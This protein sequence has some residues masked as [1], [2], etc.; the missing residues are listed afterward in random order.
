MNY[1]KKEWKSYISDG[2]ANAAIAAYHLKRPER[3][4][5][6]ATPSSLTECPRVVWMRYTRSMK[7]TNVMGWGK[8]QRNMAGRMFEKLIASQY[9]EAGQ[10]LHHWQDEE[11]G[12]SEPFVGG[13][14]LTKL[15]GTPDLLLRLVKVVISDSKTARGDGFAYVPLN[16][17]DAW[18]DPLWNKNR[19]QLNGYY[20]L[21]HANKEWFK[22]A[23]LPLPEACHLFS[24]ALD[25]GVVRREFMWE[26]TTTDLQEVK[27]YTQRWNIAYASTIMPDCVCILEDKVKFCPMA[28]EFITTKSGYKLGSKCCNES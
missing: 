24:Y 14:G 5:D 3:V 20:A 22:K 18:Q 13:E 23:L 12:Q 21:A 26:P 8:Q 17:T 15:K 16:M 6:C 1:P 4:Q 10:L 2:T 7:P 9:A 28:Y 19:I 27:N 25:D 11:A